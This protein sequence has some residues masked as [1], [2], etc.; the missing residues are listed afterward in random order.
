MVSAE[1]SAV[2][3]VRVAYSAVPREVDEVT[4]ELPAGSTLADALV[5]SGLLARHG[6]VMDEQLAVGIWA[7]AR[8]LHTPLRES[9]RVEI[10]RPLQVDPKEARRK[11][12]RKQTPKATSA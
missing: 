2:L 10:W 11:R 3:H 8:P 9:D 12:Y 1:M 7:K 5:A 4:L 6:L